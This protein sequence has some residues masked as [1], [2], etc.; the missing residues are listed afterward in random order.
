V[1]RSERAGVARAR[2]APER[3]ARGQRSAPAPAPTQNPYLAFALR[4]WPFLVAGAVF[5]LV[6]ALAFSKFGPIP[7]QSTVQVMVPSPVDP[8][9]DTIG[10]PRTVRDA[11]S[12]FAAQASSMQVFSRVS[13]AL[14]GNLNLTPADL[15]TMTQNKSLDIKPE[16][17]ANFVDI[18]VQDNDPEKAKT[19]A[20]TMADEFVKEVNQRASD[21][22]TTRQKQLEQQIEVARQNL[23]TAQLNARQLD[24]EKDLRDQRAQ[25]LL[26]QTNYQQELQRQATVDGLS[27]GGSGPAG[28]AASGAPPLADASAQVASQSLSVLTAQKKDQEAAVASL[29]TQLD[30]V[31]AALRKSPSSDLAQREQDLSTQLQTQR[32]QL[33]QTNQA[34]KQELD[35]VSASDQTK[36]SATEQ[37][38]R[39]ALAEASAKVRADWLKVIDDQ[40]HDVA[41]NIAE[42]ERQLAEIHDTLSARSGTADPAVAAAFA[43][44]Y[45]QQLLGL[46]Q[47]YTR[48]QMNLQTTTAPLQRYG[49]PSP[50]LPVVQMKKVLPIGLG[51]GVGLGAGLAYLI[52]R[53]RARVGRAATPVVGAAAVETAAGASA[54]PSWPARAPVFKLPARDAAP[55][56]R[57]LQKLYR[58]SEAQ[59]KTQPAQPRRWPA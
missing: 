19:L 48:L 20:L 10:S 2:A 16:K 32:A 30:T 56:L 25:L 41:S 54:A 3:P 1:R 37:R 47:D 50:P 29:S 24:L 57:R 44:A 42:D 14:Q 36:L 12:N 34:Y 11:A 58:E 31:R 35:R 27:P 40:E 23:T 15:T 59:T 53:R 52:E 22:V 38:Q 21:T 28:T 45:S 46:T 26:I 49:D 5:G 55:E 7:Y 8:T 43:Q 9:D 13:G 4:S 39:Q 51:V 6:A 33:L 18:T 17:G